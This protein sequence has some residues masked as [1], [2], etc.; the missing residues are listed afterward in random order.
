MKR[1]LVT[2]ASGFI[3][4]ALVPVL[5]DRGFEVHGVA[6]SP[7]PAM[8]GVTWH[9]AD[10]LSASGRA[11]GLS[12]SRPTHLVHLAWEARPGRYREDPINRLWVDASIDLLA[13]AGAQGIGRILGIGSCLEY[14]PQAGVCD[15]ASPCRPTMLYGQAKLSAAEA[16]IAAGAAWGRVFFPFGPHEPEGRLVPSL[17]R[18]LSAGEA[19]DCSHGGQLRD[20]VYVDDLAHM[21]AAVLDSDLTGAINLASGKPRSLR[22]VVEH[23]A[24]RL[25]ARHLVRF[26]AIAATGIDA[27]PII[28]AEIGR[29]RTVIA[30][31]PVIGFEAG[32]DRDLAWW[33]GRLAGNA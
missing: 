26:G 14:G 22:S 3:G 30:G 6:R 7:Q 31:V 27:E 25:N 19:F 1:V 8:A 28:A 23:F 4:R 18:S 29:L 13:R 20:F 33:A 16:Y 24:D 21:I 17:I 2:G 10:L 9:A 11:H 32:A 5:R 15:E 12:A